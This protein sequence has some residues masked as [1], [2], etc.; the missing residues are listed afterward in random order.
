M[1]SYK[2]ANA[3]IRSALLGILPKDSNGQDPIGHVQY[4]GDAD[5]FIIFKVSTRIKSLLASGRNHAV[6]SFGFVDYFS[7]ADDSAPGGYIEQIV[8]ALDGA[9]VQVGDISDVGR[10]EA[11]TWHTEIEVTVRQEA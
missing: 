2:S 10:D 8:D 1:K 9:G 4:S 11:G 3:L 5:R 7:S 6:D